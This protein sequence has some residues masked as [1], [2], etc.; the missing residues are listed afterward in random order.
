MRDGGRVAHDVANIRLVGGTP[1][2]DFVNSIHD[3]TSEFAQDYLLDGAAYL[4]W[5]VRAGV[6]TAAERRL[7]A[8]READE[9][10]AGDVPMLRAA[11]HELF[12]SV[13]EE[14]PA[15]ENAVAVLDRWLHLS[16][17]GLHLDSLAASAGWSTMR[18]LTRPC[19]CNDW[20]SRAWTRCTM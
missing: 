3:H 7:V 15:G 4:D 17:A 20:R 11:M 9:V 6:L 10:V 13:I 18:L 1:A 14:R 8:E 19:R 16:W 2:I 5:C 12:T